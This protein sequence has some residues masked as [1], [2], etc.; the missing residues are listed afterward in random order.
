MS[1]SHLSRRD[2]LNRL[3]TGT[4]ALSLSALINACAPLQVSNSFPTGK[5]PDLE[6]IIRALP[7]QAQILDGPATAVWRYEGEVVKG[8]AE[9][10]QSIPNSYLGPIFRARKGQT[11]RIHF[12]NELPEESIIH[13]HGMHVPE[14]AD[15]HPRFA[16]NKNETYIYDFKIMDRAGTYWYHPHPHGKTGEQVYMGLAG[17]FIISDDEEDALSLPSD[18]YDLPLVIQDRYFD[19]QNKLVYDSHMAQMTGFFG[20]RFLINGQA[21]YEIKAAARPYRLRILNG[22]NARTYALA[23]SDGSPLTV[24]GTD[25]GLL[26]EPVKRDTVI[27]ASAQRVDLWVD[28]SAY[29]PG[30]Q[31]QLM[32]IDPLSP[33]TQEKTGVQLLNIRIDREGDAAIPLPQKLSDLSLNDENDA[34][35]K[36]NPRIF[37]LSMGMGMQWMINGR[38]FEM[39]EVDPNEKVRLGD[40]E[41]W[42]FINDSGSRM[43][44]MPHPMHI[45]G[46]QFQIIER[47]STEKYREVNSIF[48]KGQVDEGW[49]DTVL[50]MPGERVKVLMKFEDFEG[51]YL[52]H[53]HILEHEDAGMMRNFLITA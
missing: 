43:G 37:D 12:Y 33:K 29:A 47:Q 16:V 52:Y 44:T 32:S 53:C 10:L 31:L 49:H 46:L 14:S 6:F 45:H 11:V 36:D 38:S 2:F 20:D 23:W 9:N 26:E 48:N 42:E 18:E 39:A 8:F 7:G 51:L 50:V 28:L 17:L 25:G 15:G 1:Q 41:I 40:L 34:V 19:G 22:S 4:A 30:D 35:N 24:I 5:E 13:W 27:L 21:D 3:G